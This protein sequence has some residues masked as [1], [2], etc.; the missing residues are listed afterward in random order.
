[1]E[2][3]NTGVRSW[4]KGFQQNDATNKYR[5]DPMAPKEPHTKTKHTM[6]MSPTQ[7]AALGGCLGW[8][9]ALLSV[10]QLRGSMAATATLVNSCMSMACAIHHGSIVY[11]AIPSG[12]KY[13]SP[14]RSQQ[15]ATR[16]EGDADDRVLCPFTRG[17][18][19]SSPAPGTPFECVSMVEAVEHAVQTAA[20]PKPGNASSTDLA[21]SKLNRP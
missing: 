17:H 20:D 21:D 15:F 16:L 4:H 18:D 3:L 7:Q 11:F 6:A 12:I 13:G 14:D 8:Q 9:Q 2:D 19:Q 1:M 10:L 5:G